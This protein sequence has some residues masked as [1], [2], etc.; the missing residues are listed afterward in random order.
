MPFVATPNS[1]AAVALCVAGWQ[2]GTLK[3]GANVFIYEEET[4]DEDSNVVWVLIDQKEAKWVL[5]EQ[6]QVRDGYLL[7]FCVCVFK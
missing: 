4:D 7:L 1:L 2:I 3:K 5:K 6:I